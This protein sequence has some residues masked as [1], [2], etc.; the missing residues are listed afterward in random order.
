MLGDT[1]LLVL[2]FCQRETHPPTPA[3]SGRIFV[4]GKDGIHCFPGYRIEFLVKI[5]EFVWCVCP[6]TESIM[7]SLARFA[8][9]YN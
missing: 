8:I 6:W 4:L 5:T 2:Q 9:L 3:V 1:F 7:V